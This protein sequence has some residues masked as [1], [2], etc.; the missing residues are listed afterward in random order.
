MGHLLFGFAEA[1]EEEIEQVGEEAGSKNGDGSSY[2]PLVERQ[3]DESIGRHGAIVRAVY[4]GNGQERDHPLVAESNCQRISETL[5]SNLHTSPHLL[6]FYSPSNNA[7]SGQ[8]RYYLTPMPS[9]LLLY[10]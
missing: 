1:L 6:Y 8:S 10:Q 3:V 9:L 5:E 4:P 7:T 2:L